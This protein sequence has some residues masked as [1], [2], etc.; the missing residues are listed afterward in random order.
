MRRLVLPWTLSIE[1]QSSFSGVRRYGPLVSVSQH[2]LF[3]HNTTLLP[4]RASENVV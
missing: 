1:L 2:G 4:V 3:A